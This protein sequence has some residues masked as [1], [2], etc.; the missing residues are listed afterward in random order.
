MATLNTT[1]PAPYAPAKASNGYNGSSIAHAQIP[2]NHTM[3]NT[4]LYKLGSHLPARAI[5]I[6]NQPY[7]ERYFL[8]RAFGYTAYLHRFLSCDG[9]RW[10][11]DHPWKTSYG[12]PLRG[13]YTQDKASINKAIK[14]GE[15]RR[16]IRSSMQKISRLQINKIKSS[17]WHRIVRVEP[18]TWTLFIHST[19]RIQHW[20][21]IKR[22]QEDAFYYAP[23]E[24]ETD[25]DWHLEAPR[26]KDL[27]NRVMLNS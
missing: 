6:N 10:V 25:P 11:H 13:S 3:L 24:S 26:G 16:A 5:F 27:I 2:A 9:D 12:I 4:L 17:D 22:N 1:T 7:M 8:F 21:F 20:G 23:H 18:G 14:R 19:P 15:T